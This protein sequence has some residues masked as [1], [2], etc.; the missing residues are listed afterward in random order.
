MDSNGQPIGH[1]YPYNTYSDEEYANAGVPY[2]GQVQYVIQNP[3][4]SNCPLSSLCRTIVTVG[5]RGT[6]RRLVDASP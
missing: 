3:S 5:A 4:E 1:T 6:L 2:G